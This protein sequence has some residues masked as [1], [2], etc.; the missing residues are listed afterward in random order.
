[1]NTNTNTKRKHVQLQARGNNRK[2][3]AVILNKG[4]QLDLDFI[5]EITSSLVGI[6]ASQSVL[7]RRALSCYRQHL[8]SMVCNGHR[9]YNQDD[10][11]AL[12]E[13]GRQMDMERDEMILAAGKSPM[14]ANKWRRN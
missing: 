8:I 1:M 7:M 5:K 2:Q 9:G 14:E 3:T 12:R 10:L 13:F 6:D 4:S 11:D